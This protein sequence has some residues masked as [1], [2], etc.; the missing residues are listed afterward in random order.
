MEFRWEQIY[1]DRTRRIHGSDIRGLLK[2]TSMRDMISLAGGLPAPE[3]FPIQE[4]RRA[5]DKV[6]DEQGA[7][8]LQYGVSEGYVP[9]RQFLAERL[10]RFGTRCTADN[11]LITSGSQQGLDLVARV[12]LNPGDK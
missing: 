3:A 8:A 11:V 2:V 5:F 12:L 10:N 9:L 4:F 1:A 7:V 6:L